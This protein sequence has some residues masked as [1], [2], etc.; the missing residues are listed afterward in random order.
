[1]KRI[2]VICLM[3][4]GIIVSAQVTADIAPSGQ[5]RDGSIVFYGSES[6]NKKISYNNITGIP[7]WK[8]D[9]YPAF[10]YGPDNRKF[11]L[12]WV[13]VNLATHEVEYVNKKEEVE[14][15]SRTEVSR[16]VVVDPNDSSK[17][18]TIFRDDIGDINVE[19]IKQGK[20]YYVQELNQGPVKL[21]SITHR[22]LKVGDSMF[23]TMKR[24]YFADRYDYYLQHMNR[25]EKLKKLNRDEIM[26]F[27]PRTPELEEY[28]KKNKVNFKK[29]EDVLKLLDIYNQKSQT[30]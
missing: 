16:V 9:Y 13:R 23:R 14:A 18:V 15:A 25:I 7:Y 10:L 29:E 3:H 30:Q 26:E 4:F 28:L 17:V 12:I 21:L 11:G 6:F 2:M 27:L 24:Y 1:M 8:N 22:E 20:L 19:Y 5:T